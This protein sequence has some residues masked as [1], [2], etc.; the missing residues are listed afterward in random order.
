MWTYIYQDVLFSSHMS[1]SSCMESAIS[2]FLT[3]RRL[4]LGMGM[5][6]QPGIW[7][8]GDNDRIFQLYISSTLVVYHS[9]SK[10]FEFILIFFCKWE[11]NH[12]FLCDCVSPHPLTFVLCVL[13]FL[14]LL[15]MNW[16]LRHTSSTHSVCVRSHCYHP[17]RGIILAR[18]SPPSQSCVF[19]QFIPTR[20]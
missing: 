19:Y 7:V 18:L 11:W 9:F 14:L 15:K 8:R 13:I 12:N 6:I 2:S 16:A 3:Y 20:K 1:W 4:S 5:T 17:L 10:Y